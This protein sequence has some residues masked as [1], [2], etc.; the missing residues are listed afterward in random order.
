MD[1]KFEWAEKAGS[2][3][4]RLALPG[5]KKDDFRVQVDGAGR[6]TVRGTRTAGTT[7]QSSFNKVFQLPSDANLDNIAGRFEAGVLTLT[8][9]KR[10]SSGT[11]P[12]TIEEIK[13]KLHG[14]AKPKDEGTEK[15]RQQEK[16]Q[17]EAEAVAQK[18]AEEQAR[19]RAEKEA[20]AKAEA[21]KMFPDDAEMKDASAE[22]K[23][24]DNV[25]EMD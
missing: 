18:V 11:A 14:A 16:Q 15:T 23:K 13:R 4:L 12:T 24:E 21:D 2:Y 1:P 9:P 10:A 3:V 6:L 8:V 20:A 5:F 22:D 19:K 25:E 7:G 17:E